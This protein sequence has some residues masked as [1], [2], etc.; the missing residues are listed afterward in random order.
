MY[1]SLPGSSVCG[2]LQARILE[3]VLACMCAK[4]LQSCLTLC[5]TM[6]CSPLC[7]SVHGDYPGKNTGVGSYSLLQGTF[8]TQG[9]TQVSRL[10]GIF[11][12]VWATRKTN[13]RILLLKCIWGEGWEISPVRRWFWWS[14]KEWWGWWGWRGRQTRRCWGSRTGHAG[15]WTGHQECWGRGEIPG[16][17]FDTWVEETYFS[18][19]PIS[20]TVTIS[21][22]I[23]VKTFHSMSRQSHPRSQTVWKPSFIVQFH[24]QENISFSL[25]YMLSHW[26]CIFSLPW[27]NA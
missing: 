18:P 25:I 13:R 14:R 1:C 12:N 24:T 22:D 19:T 9:W 6:D 10:E 26:V 3:W 15:W 2:I 7:S 27:I 21:L 5:D 8:L 16:G 4:S 23:S 11:F 17:I 20:N